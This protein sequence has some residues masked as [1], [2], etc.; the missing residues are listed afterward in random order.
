MER[1]LYNTILG[2]KPILPDGTSFYYSDYDAG[3]RKVYHPD[4]WPCCSG[5]LPQLAADYHVSIYLR[6]PA[7]VYVNLY[8]PSKLRW[9]TGGAVCGLTQQTKYPLDTTAGSDTGSG[10]A[11]GGIHRVSCGYQPG[12]NGVRWSA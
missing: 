7:G 11:A 1:V 4:K 6:S 5:T 10:I 8:V 12:R 3:A 9:N 2:A